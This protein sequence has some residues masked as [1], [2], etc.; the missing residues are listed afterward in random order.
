MEKNYYQLRN[1]LI[2]IVNSII[3]NS[4]CQRC[5]ID[6]FFIECPNCGYQNKK[7]EI[8]YSELKGIMLKLKPYFELYKNEISLILYS[9][10]DLTINLL[11]DFRFNYENEMLDNLNNILKKIK[12]KSLLNSDDII[13]LSIGLRSRSINNDIINN[14]VILGCLN[15]NNIFDK[16]VVSSVICMFAENMFDAKKMNLRCS[17]EYLDNSKGRAN[18]NRIR[19]N[20]SEIDSLVDGKIDVLFTLFHEYVH[21]LQYYRQVVLQSVS[22]EDIKQIKENIIA[23]H[24]KEYY[25]KNRFVCSFEKEANILGNAHLLR[26]FDEIGFPIISFEE[27]KRIVTNDIRNYDN[28]YRIVDDDRVLIDDEFMNVVTVNDF[29]F[30]PQ[31]SYEYKIYNSKVVLKKID[32]IYSDIEF[33]NSNLNYEHSDKKII[34][35]IYKDI[36]SRYP[37]KKR[38]K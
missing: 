2:N 21:V 32:E 1:E 15:K 26:Y 10:K 24:N 30:Y 29:N 14:Y 33:L 13:F 7:L 17:V 12:N 9:L 19:I 22:V 18:K 28:D 6:S 8:L 3:S 27:I 23:F 20:S 36:I 31:L 11:D 25:K 37:L 4:F 16:D 38:K 35:D 5:D 34:M